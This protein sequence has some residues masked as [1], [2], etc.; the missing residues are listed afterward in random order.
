MAPIVHRTA[1][2]CSQISAF[3]LSGMHAAE[4]GSGGLLGTF[5]AQARY[6]RF[7]PPFWHRATAVLVTAYKKLDPSPISLGIPRAIAELR[8]GTEPAQ[9]SNSQPRIL[10]AV[11]NSSINATQV[12]P[13][14]MLRG[15][16]QARGSREPLKLTRQEIQGDKL[17]TW[18]H[19]RG[20]CRSAM[21]RSPTINRSDMG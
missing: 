5:V 4:L 6:R 18:R 1:D 14:E 15:M 9:A 2:G 11:H 12:I 21:Q 7:H 20:S 16:H 19:A 10:A 13:I 8:R 3:F 17:T